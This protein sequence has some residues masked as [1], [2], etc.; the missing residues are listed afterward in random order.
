MSAGNR[1]KRPAL[2]RG[3]GAS[4]GR[5]PAVLPDTAAAARLTVYSAADEARWRSRLLSRQAAEPGERIA[6]L[7]E[8]VP[9]GTLQRHLAPPPT[10]AALEQLG[11]RFPNFQAV[12]QVLLDYAALSSRATGFRLRPLLLVGPPG[13]GKTAFARALG[14]LLLAPPVPLDMASATA[15][16]LL[17]GLDLRWAQGSPGL[18]FEQLVLA[19]PLLPANRLLLL[20]EIDKANVHGSGSPLGPLYTLLEPSTACRFRDEALDLPIDASALLWL[21][22]ANEVRDVPAP[23]LSRLEVCEIDPPQPAQRAAVVASVWSDLRETESWWAKRFPEGLGESVLDFLCQYASARELGALLRR[24]AGHALRRGAESI[25]I[26]DLRHC[27]P[28]ACV[29]PRSIGFT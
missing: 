26:E 24:G 8:Q 12:V 21:A 18:V 19:E 1:D 16:F 7:I 13:V 29:R 4:A 2:H 28:S 5:A 14:R 3:A 23:L 10:G 9:A 25:G 22:T 6:R 11:R 20:D 17:G 27:Q 15:G